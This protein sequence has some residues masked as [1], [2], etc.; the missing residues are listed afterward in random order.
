MEDEDMKWREKTAFYKALDIVMILSTVACLV[1]SI[2]NLTD[3]AIYGTLSKFSFTIAW[4]C[5]GISYWK[6]NR[7]LAI[8]DCGLSAVWFVF[9]LRSLL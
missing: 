2:L 6:T 5:M 3:V 7:T 9:A 4:L 8:I 1:L